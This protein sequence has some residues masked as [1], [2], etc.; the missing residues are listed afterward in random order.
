MKSSVDIGNPAYNESR[1]PE[2]KRDYLKE[3]LEDKDG[4]ETLFGIEYEFYKFEGINRIVTCKVTPKEPHNNTDQE[5]ID[6]VTELMTA[7]FNG[8]FW[9]LECKIE[10]NKYEPDYEPGGD[11]WSGGFADNH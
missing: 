6:S 11:A 4:N 1:R 5:L 2:F 3:Y 8:E 9:V 7:P 10:V